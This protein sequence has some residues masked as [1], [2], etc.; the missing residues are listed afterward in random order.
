MALRI[1]ANAW[2]TRV[3]ALTY[4]ALPVL[5]LGLA[6]PALAQS[7]WPE[8]PVRVVVPYPPGGGLDALARALAD[9]LLPPPPQNV[10]ANIVNANAITILHPIHLILFRNSA[11]IIYSSVRLMDI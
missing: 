6:A 8:R 7:A 11:S 3:A 10:P 4:A 1:I 9:R 5:I 2:T